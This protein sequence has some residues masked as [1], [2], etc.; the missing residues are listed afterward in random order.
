M[1]DIFSQFKGK[2]LSVQDIQAVFDVVGGNAANNILSSLK[3]L[4]EL[5][6]RTL[7]STGFASMVA[8]QKQDETLSGQWDKG[9]FSVYGNRIESD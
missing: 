3:N 7:N 2:D 9:Y 4:P 8:K 5:T 6:Q 1:T